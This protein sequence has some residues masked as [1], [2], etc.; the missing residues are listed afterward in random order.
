MFAVVVD[1]VCGFEG[2]FLHV[3]HVERALLL[4]TTLFRGYRTYASSPSVLP[5]AIELLLVRTAATLYVES[6]LL[7]KRIFQPANDTAHIS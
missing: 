2:F 4:P 3:E 6:M 5:W 7:L 1:V